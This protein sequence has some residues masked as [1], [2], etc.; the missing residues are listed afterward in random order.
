MSSKKKGEREEEQEERCRKGVRWWREARGPL[1]NWPT[2]LQN[3]EL[4]QAAPPPDKPGQ[5][6]VGRDKVKAARV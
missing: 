4:Q 2:G 6:A 3:S 1:S 5:R